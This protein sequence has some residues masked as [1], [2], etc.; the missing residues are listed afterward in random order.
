MF[1]VK[2][3]PILILFFLIFYFLI[4]FTIEPFVVKSNLKTVHKVFVA[5]GYKNFINVN[6]GGIGQLSI[7]AKYNILSHL[8]YF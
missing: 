8:N 1:T 4:L 5:D 7:F 3:L 2:C 6:F